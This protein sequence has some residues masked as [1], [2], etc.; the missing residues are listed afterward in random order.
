MLDFPYQHGDEMPRMPA[1]QG[2][3]GKIME[4]GAPLL[5]NR[6]IAK[7]RHELGTQLVGKQASSYL[8]VPILAGGEVI[9]AISV[10]STRIEN[11]FSEDDSRLLSTIA[12]NTGAAIQTARLHTETRRRAQ[13]MATLAEIGNDIAGTRELEPV[14][15]RIA[16]HALSIMHV[17]DIAVTLRDEIGGDFH[18]R[19]ALGRYSDEMKQLVVRPGLGIIGTILASGHA[20]FVNDPQND[21]RRVTV[22]GT[23]EVEEDPECLMG[24]PLISRGEVIGGLMVW[25][26]RKEG[27]FTQAELDF[28]VSVARQTTIAIESARLYLETQRRANEMSALAEVGREISASLDKMAVL[29][30]IS[31]RAMDLLAA[32][33]SAVFLME[34][35]GRSMR[36]IAARGNAAEALRSEMILLGEGIIGSL[37]AEG[38]RSL[39]TMCSMMPE[40]SSFPG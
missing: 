20:E 32:E 36:A 18:T 35:D 11:A 16:E 38:A 17:R 33:N 8:G 30:L 28:L 10:Q 6:D 1:G 40:E 2:L 34:P 26:L 9:G 3:T 37:A 12:A 21:P 13:E 14:L 39:S 27:M 29:E 25:R 15:E 31:G 24:A 23:P 22:P 4:T 5:I 19:V 7:R